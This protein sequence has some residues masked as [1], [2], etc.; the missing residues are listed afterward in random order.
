MKIKITS[1]RQENENLI[2]ALNIQPENEI[3]LEVKCF[4]NGSE[5]KTWHIDFEEKGKEISKNLKLSPDLI[6]K[7]VSILYVS[8]NNLIKLA[9]IR[10]RDFNLYENKYYQ[11][12]FED[13]KAI[14][15]KFRNEI[16]SLLFEELKN[17]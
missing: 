4:S 10:I 8:G 3:E 1:L 14:K 15:I 16:N 11:L 7:M 6:N 13:E 5:I 9:S 2:F 12:K 17:V